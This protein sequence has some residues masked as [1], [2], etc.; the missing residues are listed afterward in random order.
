MTSVVIFDNITS[1]PDVRAISWLKAAEKEFLAFP[2]EVQLNMQ[3][4][5]TIAARG[6]KADVAKPFQR[7]R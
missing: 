5:L 4:A 6:G 3:T 7:R 1:M 2:R